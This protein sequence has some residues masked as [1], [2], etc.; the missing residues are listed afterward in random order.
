[1][2]VDRSDEQLLP[3]THPGRVLAADVRRVGESEAAAG[4]Q[5]VLVD[6]RPRRPHV[7]GGRVHE[8]ELDEVEASL[9]GRGDGVADTGGVEGPGPDEPVAADDRHTP[10][11][12]VDPT[13]SSS[14]GC[15]PGCSTAAD[16][17]STARAMAVSRSASRHSQAAKVP[18]KASP[19]PVVSTGV[20]LGAGTWRSPQRAPSA[21]SVTSSS[22]TS[23]PACESRSASC[24]LTTTGSHSAR[25]SAGSSANGARLRMTLAPS[26]WPRR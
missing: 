14:G 7:E 22:G 16:A 15:A 20:T 2:D 4:L 9:T 1:Q 24:W 23:R 5:P 26:S 6:G 11:P 10:P 25:T 3:G 21:P 13:S 18:Q 19:A 8:G 12:D 17:A